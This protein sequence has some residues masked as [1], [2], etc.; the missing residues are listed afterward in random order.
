MVITND[1]HMLRTKLIFD[2]VFELPSAPGAPRREPPRLVYIEVDSVLRPDVAEQRRKREAES[3]RTFLTATKPKLK[4][5]QDLHA[6]IF[7]DHAAYSADR[8][9]SHFYK[10]PISPDVAAS[11]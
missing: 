9:M 5:L 4:T 2:T 3:L 11:Y 1:W 8:F 6:W 10:E 7:N